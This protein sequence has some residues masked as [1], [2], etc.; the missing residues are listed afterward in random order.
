M[1]WWLAVA[2]TGCAPS[3]D[4][5]STTVGT[6][7]PRV[8]VTTTSTTVLPEARYGGT[9]R[10]LAELDEDYDATGPLSSADL[11]WVMQP[12]VRVWMG[13][14]FG[15]D[16]L[17]V[18]PTSESGGVVVNADGTMTVTYRIHP[19]AVW[20]DGVPVTGEDFAFTHRWIT[21]HAEG[22]NEYLEE[23]GEYP[24]EDMLFVD[25]A[26]FVVEEKRFQYTLREASWDWWWLF[27]RV[28]PSHALEG[29]VPSDWVDRLWPQATMWV[30]EKGEPW[31]YRRNPLHWATDPA[32]GQPLPYPDAQDADPVS[33]DSPLEEFLARDDIDFLAQVDLDEDMLA[34]VAQGGLRVLPTG[35]TFEAIAF[36]FA[37]E[38]SELDPERWVD[39]LEFRQAVMYAIDR[40]RICDELFGSALRPVQSYLSVVSPSLSAEP[41]ADDPYD[42]D[43]AMRLI[44][45]LC[46][47]LGRDCDA[48]PPRLAYW[49][50][51]PEWS[52]R[53]TVPTMVDQMLGA[54]G[55][56][57]HF[58]AGPEP[59]AWDL[60]QGGWTVGPGTPSLI[61]F[62]QDPPG[63][64][65]GTPGTA[66]DTVAAQRFAELVNQMTVTFDM[67]EVAVLIREAEQILADQME[68]IPLFPFPVVYLIKPDH[69]HVPEDWTY[70]TEDSWDAAFWYRVDNRDQLRAQP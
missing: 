32:T 29:T 43:E 44:D 42:P 58:T 25:P 12:G 64:G 41:W 46:E 65:W 39:H 19:E 70:V 26:S 3:E 36:N 7:T 56:E 11:W 31:I 18:L 1:V 22:L 33:H 38:R 21:E 9:V 53:E 37:E 14:R 17:E 35:G 16:L 8:A 5:T 57:V 49:I 23:P 47:R 67:E 69:L 61:E 30:F 27:D 2:L 48:Q 40:Q 52:H 55:I 50:F 60:I 68:F 13:D 15:P 66:T 10:G 20:S 51:N 34:A 4:L 59:E 54:V 63:M 62:H 28:L 6:T 45:G 24:T